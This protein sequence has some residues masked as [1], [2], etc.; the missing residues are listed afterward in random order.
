MY[1]RMEMKLHAYLSPVLDKS[2]LVHAPADL[3]L[4]K[5]LIPIAYQA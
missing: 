2:G 1:E 3:S 5:A 4:E